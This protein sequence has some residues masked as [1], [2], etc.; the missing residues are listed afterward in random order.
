VPGMGAALMIV[1]PVGTQPLACV[2]GLGGI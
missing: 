1:A 2:E